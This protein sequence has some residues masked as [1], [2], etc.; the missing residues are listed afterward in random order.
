MSLISET[1]AAESDL[2]GLV[3][4]GQMLLVGDAFDLPRAARPAEEMGPGTEVDPLAAALAR[5]TELEH[6]HF[7]LSEALAPLLDVADLA[8]EIA[9]ERFHVA[10]RRLGAGD[11]A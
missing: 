1:N 7:E 4:L 3:D 2:A 11:P 8:L 6:G 10:A 5:A 9:A